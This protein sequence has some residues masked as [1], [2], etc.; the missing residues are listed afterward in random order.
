MLDSIFV[1]SGT[2]CWHGVFT[3][4]QRIYQE[5]SQSKK[6]NNVLG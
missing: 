5:L 6:A 4:M 2:V 1:D 3:R